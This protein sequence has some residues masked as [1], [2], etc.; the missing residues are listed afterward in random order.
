MSNTQKIAVLTGADG[1][2]GLATA[3]GLAAKGFTLALVCRTKEKGQ[4]ALAAINRVSALPHRL[5]LA[6]L[7]DKEQVYSLAD[8]LHECYDAVELLVN[9]AG[10]MSL[11]PRTAPDGL[12]L[13]MAV[14]VRAPFMLCNLLLDRL[15][16]G[17]DPRII[18]VSSALHERGKVNWQQLERYASP[19][20]DYSGWRI[21]SD[22]KLMLTTFTQELAQRT[23]QL[24]L[25]VGSLHPGVISTQLGRDFDD[26][27]WL[28]TTAFKLA[29]LFMLSPEQGA[30][31]SI[32]LA[33]DPSLAG[34]KG[35]Y[36][37][38]LK[39]KAPHPDAG[40]P[41]HGQALWKWLSAK[42][43]LVTMV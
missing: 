21:Y 27:G 42:S 13:T 11:T 33:T 16:H 15:N 14:N 38:R 10:L 3:Q 40:V 43:G 34:K 1:G 24:P 5:F 25:T 12:E 18:N 2:I 8:A 31:P 22:S 23:S 6:D 35:I 28:G 36:L 17:H 30:A 26:Y 9:N 39:A 37:H 19:E 32:K 20:S 29:K 4:A 41:A 7:A